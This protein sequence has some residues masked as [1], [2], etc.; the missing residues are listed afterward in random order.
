M[1][2]RFLIVCLA[3]CALTVNAL[4]ENAAEIRRRMEARLPDI[5]R[6]KT[7]QIIGE[8]NRGLLQ[9]VQNGNREADG[10][11]SAENA[12]RQVVYAEI[13][14]KTGST[15]EAVGHQRAKKL[16]ENSRAGVWVQNEAGQWA[17]KK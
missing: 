12:D 2:T 11:V 3:L 15:S 8:T 4:A 17:L 7:Q 5:D 14:Q 16:A 6:L 10:V 1:N 9:V 13:A